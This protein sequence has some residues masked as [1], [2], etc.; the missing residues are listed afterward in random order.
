MPSTTM[1]FPPQIEQALKLTSGAKYLKCALQVNPWTYLQRN[2]KKSEFADEASYNAAIVAACLEQGI[3]VI[4]LTDHHDPTTIEGL[5]RAAEAAGI[6]VF[7][8]FEIAASDGVHF[9]CLFEPGT[10]KD[11][12][13]IELGGMGVT[14]Q[15]DTY[16]TSTSHDSCAL[17]K[18]CHERG[19]ICIAAHVCND[20]GLLK[21]LNGQACINAWKSPDL[22]VVA[23][24]MRPKE[25]TD[26][27]KREILTGQNAEYNHGRPG[28]RP[29]T[30]IH[31]GD[32]DAPEHLSEPSRWTWIK[33]SERTVEGLRYAFLDGE[34][35]VRSSFDE[36]PTEHPEVE[37]IAFTGGFLGGGA[38]HFS[39]NLNALIG[40]RGTGKSTVVEAIRF[41]LD[42]DAPTE[43]GRKEHQSI[44]KGVFKAGTKVSL[45]VK[46]TRPTMRRYAIERSVGQAPV[47]FDEDGERLD[48][49]PRDL[50]PNIDLYGQREISDMANDGEGRRRVLDRFRTLDEAHQRTR[51][52]LLRLLKESREAIEKA[53]EGQSRLEER[54]NALPGLIEQRAQYQKLE[55]DRKLASKNILERER[56]VFKDYVGRIN[57]ID[58]RIKAAA[59]DLTVDAA[60]LSE[61][62]LAPFP[63]YELLS[64]LRAPLAA[65][66]M[67]L[68]QG[69]QNLEEALA[70]AYE[71]A[72][73][74]NESWK[75][76]ER[77]V[78]EAYQAALREL[79]REKVDGSEYV[80]VEKRI[81]ELEPLK[82]QVGVL[83]ARHKALQEERTGLVTAWEAHQRDE[84]STYERAAKKVTKKL[85]KQVKIRV[86][87]DGGR[88]ALETLLRE[89]VGGNL[90][91]AL[92]RINSIPEFTMAHFADVCSA[93]VSQL[94]ERYGVSE[95]IAQKIA[96]QAP[97]LPMLIQEAEAK[98]RTDIE[99]N[100]SAEG[101][102]EEWRALD[103]L[104]MG[105]KA[106]ALL[107]V[108]FLEG[109]TPLIIDQPE[110]DLDNR[111]IAERV[112]KTI[113]VE[114][115]RR[116]FI[117]STHNANIPVNGDAEL[118]VA[119]QPAPADAD[120]SARLLP[121][122]MGALDAPE[123]K[124]QVELI[125]EGGREAFEGRR[126]RYDF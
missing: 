56:R 94:M 109:D 120:G 121:S 79:Q 29:P 48:L 24:P 117:F 6:T 50:F 101:Q 3:E 73:P 52:R 58:E 68:T 86:E 8:G 25:L 30:C 91:A 80:L 119:M 103:R 1:I 97:R 55:L 63:S 87:S 49:T 65:L 7:P 21:D 98:V 33:M 113:R 90:G 104:S 10:S 45:L 9:L 4:G 54:L 43:R 40:G 77:R 64:G 14:S 38:I 76:R 5:R 39:P 66:E 71:A 116:Q 107:L 15:G 92:N 75:E 37:V 74:I 83:E 122:A 44:V 34:S 99:L 47:V 17:P 46:V 69:F 102:P 125:L 23:V 32:V 12:L 26:R 82:A 51:E 84:L 59:E 18:H 60:F 115:H 57:S 70:R 36:N 67:E 81:L 126:R 27:A 100:V 31:A 2:H 78:E 88:E 22:L 114:K 42:V 61:T 72:K 11:Q 112:V 110:D 28:G 16:V 106:T 53:C 85:E 105:Q 62:A 89:H 93:G 19:A 35:R 13:L 123:I 96:A 41:A 95:T 108:L 118:I 111:F 20:K 124:K